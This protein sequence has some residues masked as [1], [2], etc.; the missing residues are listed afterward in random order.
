MN[1]FLLVILLL[2]VYQAKPCLLKNNKDYLSVED[3]NAI[4]G[5]FIMFVFFRHITSYISDFDPLDL[6]MLSL[7]YYLDQLIVVM[8]LFYSGYGVAYSMEHKENYMKSFPKK[9]IGFLLLEYDIVVLLYFTVGKLLGK[10]YT[11]KKL[12]LSLIAVDS[13]GNSNWYIFTI[14]ILYLITFISWLLF[15]KKRSLFLLMQLLLTSG[16]IFAMMHWKDSYWYNTALAYVFGVFWCI[17]KQHIEKLLNNHII[18]IL[19]F[20]ACIPAYHFT[21]TWSN[22]IVMY[23]LMSVF[24]AL[25]IILITYKIRLRNTV[26]ITLGRHLFPLYIL[27]RLPMLLLQK[28]TDTLRNNTVFLV[29]SAIATIVITYFYCKSKKRL[30]TE[31]KKLK[32]LIK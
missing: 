10:K 30:T 21:R 5:I 26:L 20:V 4:K 22:H 15:Q 27:Q 8:F 23:E 11:L 24:F 32:N 1:V 3:T 17:Y 19:L 29:Y 6:R 14:L 16:Y 28:K 9:R 12:A 7:N 13:C 25:L 2:T 31:T 18:Y